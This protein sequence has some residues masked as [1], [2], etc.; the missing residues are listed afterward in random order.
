MK[1]NPGSLGITHIKLYLNKLKVSK[2]RDQGAINET[3][4]GAIEYKESDEVFVN[5]NEDLLCKMFDG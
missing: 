5:N 1:K 3:V 4:E 2:N